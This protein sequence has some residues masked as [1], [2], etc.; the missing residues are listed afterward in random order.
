MQY[1]HAMKMRYGKDFRKNI[2]FD[3]VGLTFCID[4]LIPGQRAWE[5]VTYQRALVDCR[6]KERKVE[7]QR[8]EALSST[9]VDGPRS[10]LRP[11]TAGL[12]AS[13]AAGAPSE[14]RLSSVAPME[15]EDADD[16]VWG[17]DK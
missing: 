6:N 13:V 5:T 3:D 11:P 2:R 12:M 16:G 7:I 14:A 15:D 1:G 4:V 17:S 9:S 8:G 10:I